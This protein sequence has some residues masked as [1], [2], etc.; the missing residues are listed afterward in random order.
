M[1][2]ARP[3][4]CQDVVGHRPDASHQC[5]LDPWLPPS[6]RSLLQSALRE[7]EAP[8]ASLSLGGT[9]FATAPVLPPSVPEAV[10]TMPNQ[11]LVLRSAGECVGEWV[12]EISPLP[13]SALDSLLGSRQALPMPSHAWALREASPVPRHRYGIHG[14]QPSRCPCNPAIVLLGRCTCRRLGCTSISGL[15]LILNQSHPPR[16]PLPLGLHQ[17]DQ[18]PVSSRRG[19]HGTGPSP[20]P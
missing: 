10:D 12:C 20:A 1:G 5:D 8:A 2:A 18:R 3:V 11:D 14:M 7:A 15:A 13:C 4:T 6:R 9:G 19:S 17:V 16:L